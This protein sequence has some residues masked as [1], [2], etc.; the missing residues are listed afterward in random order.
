MNDSSDAA[1]LHVLTLCTGEGAA[2]T[3]R[4]KIESTKIADAGFTFSFAMYCIATVEAVLSATNDHAKVS[5]DPEQSEAR[6]C[7][8]GSVGQL[9]FLH[10]QLL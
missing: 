2:F 8:C 6:S 5:A 3:P 7:S 10:I 1:K 4:K 9:K